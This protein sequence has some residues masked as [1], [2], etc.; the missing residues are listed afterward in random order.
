MVNDMLLIDARAYCKELCAERDYPG[1]SQEFI[2]AIEVAIAN[3]GDMPTIDAEPVRHGWWV[4]TGFFTSSKIP[5]YACSVCF[6]EVYDNYI[7][8]H[9]YC[10]HCGAQMD[11][12]R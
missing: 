3:L 2:D 5:I 8:C 11:G 4:D 10:L 7:N 1:R 6:N 9:N 12:E